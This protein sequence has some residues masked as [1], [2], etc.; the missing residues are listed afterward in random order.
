MADERQRGLL[1]RFFGGFGCVFSGLVCFPPVVVCCRGSSALLTRVDS[2]VDCALLLICESMCP[3]YKECGRKS[4]RHANQPPL[5]PS[6]T[7]SRRVNVACS[8][9]Q[10][11][12][13]IVG[14]GDLARKEASTQC[15]RQIETLCQQATA[16]PSST[17]VATW[18]ATAS[19][20]SAEATHPPTV[21][22]SPGRL[23]E[24]LCNIL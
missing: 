10:Q 22:I 12:L 20:S 9:A 8:R 13:F 1:G 14:R 4:F 21:H 17:T 15:W 19:Q 16:A 11:L 18:V 6:N 7:N 3:S 2:S 24:I 23:E 5:P